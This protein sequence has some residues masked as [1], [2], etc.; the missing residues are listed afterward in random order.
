LLS[1]LQL[2]VRNCIFWG[3]AFCWLNEIGR[4]VL[5]DTLSTGD[6]AGLAAVCSQRTGNWDANALKP[7]VNT[8]KT[9]E[10]ELNFGCAF[11]QQH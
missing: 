8:D 7:P 10:N 11:V 3:R 6:L 4:L 2:G 1:S 5:T 9:I